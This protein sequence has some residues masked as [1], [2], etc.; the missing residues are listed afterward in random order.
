[1]GGSEMMYKTVRALFDYN[2]ITGHLVRRQ[3]TS[4][5]AQRGMLVGCINSAGYAV[6]NIDRKVQYVH[7]IIWLWMTGDWPTGVVDHI[8]GKRAD[9]RWDNLRDV[10]YSEN[11]HNKN[12][13]SGVYW[14]HRDQVWVACI[15]VNGDKTH[16]GQSKDREEAEAMYREVKKHYRPEQNNDHNL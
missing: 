7:R 4:S 6:V 11:C 9:N 14:A 16:I 3:T 5:R 1:M 15:Q 8:N 12:V 13:E 2:P 10:S